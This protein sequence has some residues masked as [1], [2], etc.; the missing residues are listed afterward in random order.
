[1]KIRIVAIECWRFHKIQRRERE[2][3]EKKR[4]EQMAADD[5]EAYQ[6][7]VHKAEKQRIQVDLKKQNKKLYVE[8]SGAA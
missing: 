7:W 3:Q 4:V 2:K 8:I 5:A 6:D 1:M